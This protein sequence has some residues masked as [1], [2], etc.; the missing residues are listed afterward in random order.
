MDD[1][2]PIHELR[3]KESPSAYPIREHEGKAQGFNDK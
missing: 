1:S 2:S 3:Q